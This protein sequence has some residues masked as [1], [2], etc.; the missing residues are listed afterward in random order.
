MKNSIKKKY[1]N[2]TLSYIFNYFFR[3]SVS[4]MKDMSFQGFPQILLNCRP[5]G[6]QQIQ[7]SAVY[8]SLLFK[9]ILQRSKIKWYPQV[10]VLVLLHQESHTTH[11][12]NEKAQVLIPSLSACL[13]ATRGIVIAPG[14]CKTKPIKKKKN[15]E[16][17]Y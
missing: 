3:V 11:F 14:R 6:F 5:K 1:H 7:L 15:S 17:K 8:Q 10:P 12:P 2:Y 4:K 16:L 9:T 13:F